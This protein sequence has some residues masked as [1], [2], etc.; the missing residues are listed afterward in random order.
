MQLDWLQEEWAQEE[1]AHEE[2]APLQKTRNQEIEADQS[3]EL[4][5]LTCAQI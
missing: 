4:L 1:W 5:C 2:Q 3:C